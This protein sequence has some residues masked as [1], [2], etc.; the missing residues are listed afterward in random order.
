MPE[1]AA[2]TVVCFDKPDH[3][4]NSD[5]SGTKIGNPQ[6]RDPPDGF[7]QVGAGSTEAQDQR[8]QIDGAEIYGAEVDGT[9]ARRQDVGP[10][11]GPVVTPLV[12]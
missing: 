11:H 3:W 1:R 9:E 12:A 6:E 2:N 7:A 10:V 5:G 4:E 8:R